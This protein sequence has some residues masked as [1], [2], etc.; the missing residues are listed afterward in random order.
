MAEHVATPEQ[1][2]FRD[3]CRRWLAENRPAAPP[4]RM[5]IAAIE[6]M[7]EEQRTWLSAWQRNCWEAGLVGCDY[8]KEY[9]GGGHKGFQTIATQELG[10]AGVPYMRPCTLCQ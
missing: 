1:R 7:T 6:V 8:P 5:P 2:E 10:R 4:F 3:Y 9:G